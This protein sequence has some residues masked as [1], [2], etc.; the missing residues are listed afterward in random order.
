M[1][2]DQTAVRRLARLARLHLEPADEQRL[3]QQLGDVVAWIDRLASVE[4]SKPLADDRL[5]DR[6]EPRSGT[7]TAA[8][9]GLDR[10]TVLALAPRHR[11][12]FFVVPRAGT[13]GEP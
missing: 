7:E 3:A 4:V 2:F 11:D 5:D 8:T 9:A 10:C 1:T 13:G 12:G 6:A